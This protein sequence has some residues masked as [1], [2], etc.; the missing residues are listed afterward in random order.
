MAEAALRRV[1]LSESLMDLVRELHP[2][3][4]S[5]T[6]DGVRETLEIIQ[7]WAPLEV[8]EVPTGTRVFDWTVP[9]EWNI[10]DAWIGDLSGRRVVDFRRS[11]LHVVGYSQPVRRLISR[12]E[13]LAHIHSLPDHPDWI[14]YRTSYYDRTWGFCATQRQVD[15]L[16]EPEYEVCIDAR[17]EPGSLSY[18]ELFLPGTS[19]EEILVSTH[20]CHP[21]LCNDNLSGI[22]VAALLAAELQGRPRRRGLRFLWIPGTIGSLTW[23]ARNAGRV[24][25]IRGGLT[26]TCLGDASPFTYKRSFSGSAEVDR[27]AAY[28]LRQSGQWHQMVDFAPWGY[29]ERQY[30]SPGFRLGVGA[31]SRATHGDFPE[32]HTSGDDLAF[33]SGDRLAESLGVVGQILQLLDRNAKYLNLLP[34]GEPQLGRRGI[35]RSIGG[36]GDPKPVELA[37]LWLLSLSDGDH[38]LIDVA[39]R[40]DL[41]FDAV[42]QAAEILEGQ[43][44]LEELPREKGARR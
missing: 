32:Y 14:P 28:A 21:S 7:R 40:A 9:D 31:L 4:R 33:V 39:E 16:V 13:L 26:L 6:G 8:H 29:D 36:G 19:D 41:D 38:D 44:L 5:L 20:I 15:S 3:C 23:L 17:L 37:L 2:I 42:A 22:A 10:R 12:R 43:G 24:D 18:G 30:E 34:H 27:V 35:Y 11:N 25:R 1:S